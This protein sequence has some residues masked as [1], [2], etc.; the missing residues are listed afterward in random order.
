[1]LHLFQVTLDYD[2]CRNMKILVDAGNENRQIL[3]YS[4]R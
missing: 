2:G 3:V 1:M 4:L